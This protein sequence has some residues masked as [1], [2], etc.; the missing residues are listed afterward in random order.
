M[1]CIAS[2]TGT[3][4]GFFVTSMCSMVFW[5][6]LPLSAAPAV[7]LRGLTLRVLS[8]AMVELSFSL[9]SARVE[10]WT[11]A[12]VRE[13]EKNTSGRHG[14]PAEWRTPAIAGRGGFVRQI[15][16]VMVRTRQGS[17]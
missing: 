16:Q 6:Y 17:V 7:A 9:A 12:C 11:L 10:S 13:N 3:I 1:C 14:G 8:W 4:P 2:T 15:L 5:K